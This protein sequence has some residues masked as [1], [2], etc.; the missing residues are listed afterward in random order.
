MGARTDQLHVSIRP[1]KLK[2]LYTF[3]HENKTNCLARWPQN[4]DIR[5]AYLDENTQIGVIELKTCIQA[6]VA[7]SPELVA[8]LGQDYTVYAYDYSEYDTP[9]VGQGMLS[10][11]LASS[12]STPSAPAHRSKTIVTG[13]VCKNIMGLFSDN[14]QETLEVKLRLVPVPSCLQSEYIESMNRYRNLSRVMPEGFDP[15]AW[16]NFLQAN[17]GIMQLVGQSRSES[18][19]LASG[20]RNPVGLEHVQRL[21]DRS[22]ASADQAEQNPISQSDNYSSAEAIEQLPRPASQAS[23]IRSTAPP[24]RGRG[25]PPKPW[26]ELSERARK[27]RQE[28]VARLESSDVG[29]GSNEDQ[30]DEGPGKKRAKV[31]RAEYPGSSGFGKQPELRVAASTAA[32]LRIHQPTAIRPSHQ[33]ASSLEGPPREP[34]PIAKPLRD[35]SRPSLPA[36]KSHLRRESLAAKETQYESPFTPSDVGKHPESD[37][38]SAE[39]SGAESV[40][41]PADFASSPPAYPGSMT[42]PSSPRLPSLPLEMDSGF[43]SGTIDD[44]FEDEE[45][46][47]LDDEDIDIAAQYMKRSELQPAQ[48]AGRTVSHDSGFD[49]PSDQAQQSSTSTNQCSSF[50]D[51]LPIATNRATLSRTGSSG[52]IPGPLALGRHQDGAPSSDAIPTS[53]VGE[54]L[55]TTRSRNRIGSG[56]GMKRKAAIQS[57]LAETVAK[58][59]MPPFC[60]N[61]GA[62][63]TPTWRKAWMRVHSGTAEN[64]VISDEEGGIVA[65]QTLQTDNDGQVCLFRIIKR[66]LLPEDEGFTESLLCNP[67]GIWL[68]TRKCMRP[69]D[70]WDKTQGPDGGA[71]GPRRRR[72]QA[73][74]RNSGSFSNQSASEDAS[75]G[76]AFFSDGSSPADANEQMSESQEP[77]LPATTR[78]RASSFQAERSKHNGS[79]LNQSS[80]AA[81]LQRAIQSSPVRCRGSQPLQKAEKALTPRPTRRVLFPSP[82]QREQHQSSIGEA[83][84]NGHGNV[85][86]LDWHARDN[87]DPANK[88]NMPPQ[89]DGEESSTFEE[90]PHRSV[91]PT[92]R[93]KS[94]DA[95]FKTPNRSGTPDRVAPTTGDFFSSAAKALLRPQ[96]TPKHAAS[97]PSS[98]QPLSEISPFTAQINSILSDGNIAS[99]CGSQFEFPSLPSLSNTPHRNRHD[100]DF[101]QFDPQDLLSTDVPIASSPPIEGWFGV[102]E[103]PAESD[104][105]RDYPFPGSSPPSASSQSSSAKKT[106]TPPALS[107]DDNGRARLDFSAAVGGCG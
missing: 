23:S 73:R 107:V 40:T 15:H 1:M 54:P 72:S 77:R 65:W 74:K 68:H 83:A 71:G 56:S 64:V 93:S 44:L 26:N 45:Y 6:I 17:P 7:A 36:R 5:T 105:W 39:G 94:G 49:S 14:T 46:R 89:E 98:V 81:A 33:P 95:S 48:P 62:I 67:C 52:N 27:R 16:T 104:F 31:T 57:K 2:V 42:A 59:E 58:G 78:P 8:K 11:V 38:N 21:M 51:A 106:K 87:H 101:S 24:R 100:F 86:S 63:E 82:R 61:C 13:R 70:V 91:T 18:P 29:Y 60:E 75:A 28:G 9:Q 85:E 30:Q 32:S 88:E 96:I 25:R 12:S 90:L 84:S 66:S 43:L 19:T 4:I 102:Y 10:W 80:A 50:D 99:P 97:R 37:N 47:P 55:P 79:K 22:T 76:S 41:T 34:T 20:Q 69:K 3:D 103:D 35:R 92:P 53:E